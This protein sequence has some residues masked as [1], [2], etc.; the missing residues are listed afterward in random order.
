M[1]KIVAI[2]I[3]LSLLLPSIVQADNKTLSLLINNRYITSGAPPIIIDGSTY[4]PLRNLFENL[5]F[6]VVYYPEYKSA[7]AW[8]N[9]GT[10]K[11]AFTIDSSVVVISTTQIESISASATISSNPIMYNGSFYVPLRAFGELFNANVNYDKYTYT[12]SLNTTKETINDSVNRLIE[13]S[14]DVN[15]TKKVLSTKEIAK[16]MD[17]VGYVESYD[18]NG[19]TYSSGSGFVISGGLFITNYHVVKDGYGITVKLDGEVYNNNGWYWMKNEITDLYGTYL[20]TSYTPTGTINGK[21]P[22][23]SLPYNVDIPE[24]GETIYA[25]GSPFGLENTISVGIVSGIREDNGVTM[26]QHTADTDHGSSGGALLNEY[27]EVIGVTSSG[28]EGSNL[29]FA[30][31]IKYVID[32]L[33]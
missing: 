1:K 3:L 8:Y 4:I 9:R 14:D 13:P 7:V 10:F 18:K 33:N 20:S 15:T 27:G 24:V 19:T 25:I 30:I 12:V 2:L 28:V 6:T 32:E 21:V 16:L 31:P 22:T 23:K 29:E 17:R 5:E 26:I 11:I